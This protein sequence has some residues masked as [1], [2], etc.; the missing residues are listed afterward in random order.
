MEDMTA[1]FKRIK[2]LIKLLDEQEQMTKEIKE[3][4][5]GIFTEYHRIFNEI[6]SKK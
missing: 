4:S 6:D 1:L 5:K 3:L 2:H